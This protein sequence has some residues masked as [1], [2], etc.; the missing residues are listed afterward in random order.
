MGAPPGATA[1]QPIRPGTGPPELL[2]EEL[3]EDDEELLEDELDDELEDELLELD[4]ELDELEEE[5]DEL[6]ELEDELDEEPPPFD[7]TEHSFT[8]PAVR[9]PKVASLQTKLPTR[10]LKK[11]LS[12][13]PKATL[14][15]AA[16]E[17]VLPSEH[18]VT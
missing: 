9:P 8:P 5:L 4:D 6:D 17:Q 13:R 14:V 10:V 11:N 1:P 3:D 2:V 15:D 7:G 16:T 12:A 18:R